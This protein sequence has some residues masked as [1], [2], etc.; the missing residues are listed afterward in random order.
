MKG[1]YVINSVQQLVS[2]FGV[3]KEAVLNGNLISI[4]VKPYRKNRKLSQNALQHVIYNEISHYLVQKG[5]KDWSPDFVKKQLKNKFLGWV[6]SEFVDVITGEVIIKHELKATSE[7][8]TGESYHF[9]TQIIEWAS[10]IGCYINIPEDCEYRD[11]QD[12][13][14]S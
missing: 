6:G 13:Q 9:T 4:Q 10:S 5:R 11:L 14:N 1:K 8:D 12:Q 7:L 2:L 3:I